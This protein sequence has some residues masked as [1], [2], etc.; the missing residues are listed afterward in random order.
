MQKVSAKD[1]R[2]PRLYAGFRDD[3]RKRIIELKKRRRVVIGPTVTLVFENRA[4]VIYQ[5]EEMCRAESIFEPEKVADEIAV[6]NKILPEPGELAATLFIEL[7]DPATLETQLDELVGLQNHV[8]L[9]VGAARIAATFD[10][11]QFAADK[12]AAVQYLRFPLSADAQAR[13]RTAGTPLSVVIDHPHYSHA[14]QLSDATR[15][16]LAGDLD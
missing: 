4:T 9:T 14:A 16:E 7:V 1:V 8:W 5:I 3:L 13:L 2:G 12:L 6:Y 11:E 15:A 10:A